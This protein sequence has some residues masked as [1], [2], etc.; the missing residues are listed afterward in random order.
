MKKTQGFTLIELM[1]VVAIIGI[2]TAVAVPAY[3]S[4]IARSEIAA[5]LYEIT[6]SRAQFEVRLNDGQTDISVADVGL[7]PSTERCSDIAVDYSTATGIGSITCTLK[8]SPE[9]VGR[10]IAVSRGTDGRWSCIT[11]QG[12]ADTVL[13]SEYKPKGCT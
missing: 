13:K 12:A 2:L 9:V 4:Y 8:G 10:T 11:G 7:Q 1:I 5:S 6:P 3:K